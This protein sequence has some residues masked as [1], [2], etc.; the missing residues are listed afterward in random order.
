M[1]GVD[2]ELFSVI[3]D[4][5][6][7]DTMGAAKIGEFVVCPFVTRIEIDGLLIFIN[8]VT[9]PQTDSIGGAERTMYPYIVPG[10]MDGCFERADSVIGCF[11][12]Q[13]IFADAGETKRFVGKAFF[14][15]A[16]KADRFLT[17][18][19]SGYCLRNSNHS[20]HKKPI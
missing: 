3:L 1:A 6:R 4:G 8:G 10:E 14:Q 20:G 16:S 17:I 2:L 12:R 18:S 7:I 9:E 19:A 5:I 11:D 15:L 13:I